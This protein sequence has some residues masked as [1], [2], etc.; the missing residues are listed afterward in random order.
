MDRVGILKVE[1][2]IH[3]IK[4]TVLE[5][6]LH[7]PVRPKNPR[8]PRTST[9]HPDRLACRRKRMD[10]R[11]AKRITKLWRDEKLEDEMESMKEWGTGT[12]DVIVSSSEIMSVV[13]QAYKKDI[14]QQKQQKEM[15]QKYA[16]L[17]LHPH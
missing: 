5:S 13:D 3:D 15:K 10:K 2:K 9:R 12:V 7:Q 8:V 1:K 4:N 11:H 16:G 14:A 6:S 17:A